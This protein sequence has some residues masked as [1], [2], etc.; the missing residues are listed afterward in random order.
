MTILTT[1]AHMGAIGDTLDMIK[2]RELSANSTIYVTPTHS[3][4]FADKL[5]LTSTPPKAQPGNAGVTRTIINRNKEVTINAGLAN[6]RIVPIVVKLE[7]SMP[8]GALETDLDLVLHGIRGFT[9]M[10]NL[11]NSSLFLNAIVPE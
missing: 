9:Q 10:N 1:A 2:F 11:D 6:E 8:V 7:V 4:T 5:T 3:S